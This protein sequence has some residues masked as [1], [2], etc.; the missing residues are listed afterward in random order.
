VVSVNIVDASAPSS[1]NDVAAADITVAGYGVTFTELDDGP[2]PTAFVAAT[3][4]V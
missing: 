1:H 4:T 3:L 2:V